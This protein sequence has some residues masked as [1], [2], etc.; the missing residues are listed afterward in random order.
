MFKDPHLLVL[1]DSRDKDTNVSALE[2]GTRL[3]SVIL[4]RLTGGDQY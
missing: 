4:S 1:F 2:H 3:A